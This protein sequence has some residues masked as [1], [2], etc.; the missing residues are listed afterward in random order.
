MHTF[1]KMVADPGSIHKDEYTFFWCEKAAEEY[2]L[3]RVV[4]LVCNSLIACINSP[5]SSLECLIKL[6]L[7]TANASMTIFSVYTP[8]LTASDGNKDAFYDEV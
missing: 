4:P 6:E 5:T 1:R 2:P 3:Y 8:T 7:N